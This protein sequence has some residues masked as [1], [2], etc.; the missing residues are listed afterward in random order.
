[1]HELAKEIIGQRNEEIID[2]WDFEKEKKLT[3][4]DAFVMNKI[5]NATIWRI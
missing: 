3:F 1:M 2:E 5:K 4:M